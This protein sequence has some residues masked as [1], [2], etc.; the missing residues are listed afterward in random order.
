MSGALVCRAEVG[1]GIW[2]M[3]SIDDD[4]PVTTDWVSAENSMNNNGK[5]RM[6]RKTLGALSLMLAAFQG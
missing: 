4:R 3:S 6:M 1:Q 5:R 2:T